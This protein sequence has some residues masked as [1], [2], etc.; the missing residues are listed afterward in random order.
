[1]DPCNVFSYTIQYN[2]ITKF[3]SIFIASVDRTAAP[4]VLRH[5]PSNASPRAHPPALIY[6]SHRICFLLLLLFPSHNT[7]VSSLE[8]LRLDQIRLEQHQMLGQRFDSI[9]LCFPLDQHR[10]G[11]HKLPFFL[12]PPQ[13]VSDTLSQVP[14]STIESLISRGTIPLLVPSPTLPRFTSQLAQ[15]GKTG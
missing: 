12:L 11:N 1:M 4:L 14:L 15:D 5:P 6:T 8:Q 9:L 13:L 7:M 3:C 10:L 2:T